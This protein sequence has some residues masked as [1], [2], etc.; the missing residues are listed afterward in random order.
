MQVLHDVKHDL[1]SSSSVSHTIHSPYITR[2]THRHTHAT[3]PRKRIGASC[4][5]WHRHSHD[6]LNV[7][8]HKLPRRCHVT[9]SQPNVLLLLHASFTVDSSAVVLICSAK[10]TKQDY[11]HAPKHERP[12]KLSLYVKMCCG[13]LTPT[14]NTTN[15]KMNINMR[16]RFA[17]VSQLLHVAVETKLFE[18]RWNEEESEKE[19]DEQEFAPN[20]HVQRT[21]CWIARQS[22]Q[23]WLQLLNDFYRNIVSS[24]MPYAPVYGRQ[25]ILSRCDID[26]R[27][28]D[29][30]N[31]VTDMKCISSFVFRFAFT[32]RIGNVPTVID[33]LG[34]PKAISG[35]CHQ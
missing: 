20:S 6:A 32:A 13:T 16:F 34:N 29:N 15:A 31:D 4:A 7:W 5:S 28:T 18:M 17:G 1:I 12:D 23:K 3:Q 10:R 19:L 9:N 33:Q 30:C 35:V 21:A 27:P 24:S 22:T 26:I 11:L 25:S 2:A 8:T 14:W